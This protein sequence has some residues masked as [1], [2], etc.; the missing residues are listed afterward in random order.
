[1][2]DDEG[3]RRRS[4]RP[5]ASTDEI[6][7]VTDP[8]GRRW[9]VRHEAGDVILNSWGTLLPPPLDVLVM[10]RDARRNGWSA[11]MA[12][13][14]DGQERRVGLGTGRSPVEALDEVAAALSE[15]RPLP[16]RLG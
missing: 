3:R 16:D 6:R 11:I 14:S 4:R 2:A 10:A 7:R 5:T 1:M 15:G 8:E 12:N 13:S 9:L